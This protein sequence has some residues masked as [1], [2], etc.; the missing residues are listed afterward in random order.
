MKAK[1]RVAPKAKAARSTSPFLMAA[2]KD[3]TR[4]AGFAVDFQD[5]CAQEMDRALGIHKASLDSAI[6]LHSCVIEMYKTVDP[7]SNA[8]WCAPMLEA[9][10]DA[11]AKSFAHCMKLHAHCMEMHR[12]W[13]TLLAP[14]TMPYREVS[15]FMNKTTA[16][17]EELAYHMDIAIGERHFDEDAMFVR[18]AGFHGGLAAQAA[19]SSMD[20]ATGQRAA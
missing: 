15:T 16:T 3:Q 1:A 9:L 14:N 10:I 6:G 20:I 4:A 18:H 17:A 8:S 2:N 5:L 11:A 12:T 13:V 7:Y 19:E